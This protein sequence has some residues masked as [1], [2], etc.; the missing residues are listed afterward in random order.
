MKKLNLISGLPR[1]GSS[2]LS[3]ILNQNPRFQAPKS[4]PV[5]KIV[6]SIIQ[7]ANAE[8]SFRTIFPEIKRKK[9]IHN[10]VSSYYE[11]SKEVVFDNSTEWTLL[12]PLMKSVFPEV[13]IICCVREVPLILDSFEHLL[14]KNPFSVSSLFKPEESIDVYSRTQ[15]LLRAD[16]TLGIALNGLKQAVYGGERE[17]VLLVNYEDLCQ[18]PM[19]VMKDVYL[20][21]NEP[22]FQH[23]FNNVEVSSDEFDNDVNLNEQHP[24][25][26]KVEYIV[27]DPII[28]PDLWRQTEGLSFWKYQG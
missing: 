16:R 20:F 2:L 23:D 22:Y 26:K 6:R 24:M 13:K 7:E 1:S 27:K 5:A 10:L 4:G 25:R 15:S 3:A 8:A 21:L 28:P 9:L 19:N 18:R 12:T 17:I 11:D 14:R